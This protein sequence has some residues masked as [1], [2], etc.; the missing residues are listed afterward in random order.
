LPDAYAAAGVNLSLP[1]FAGGYY[2]G[3]QQEAALKAAASELALKDEENSVIQ[4]VH[5]AWL[6]SQNALERLR[7]A[8]QLFDNARRS[9]DLAKARYDN[10]LSSIVEYNQAQLNLISAEITYTNT[11]YEYR[12]HI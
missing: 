10:G 8:R 4:E 9:S 5:I 7:I 3:R 11:K 2:S 6:N 1:L 12:S